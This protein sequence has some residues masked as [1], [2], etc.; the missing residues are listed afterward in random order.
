MDALDRPGIVRDFVGG[1]VRI[2]LYSGSA[3]QEL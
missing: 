2:V 3:D 1:I